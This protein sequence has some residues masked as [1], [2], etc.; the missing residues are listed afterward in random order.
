[1]VNPEHLAIL[2]EGVAVWNLWRAENPDLRPD[3]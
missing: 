3:A 2:K 1:M